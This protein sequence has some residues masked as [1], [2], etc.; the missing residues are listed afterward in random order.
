MINL[1]P[2]KT[3]QQLNAAHANTILLK[4]LVWL[5]TAVA[6]L[7][8]A[9]SVSYMFLA[10]AQTEKQDLANNSQSVSSLY[11]SAQTKLN[12]IN[13]NIATAKTLLL[14]QISYSEAITNLAS[15]MP[16]G[17]VLDKLVLG[18]NTGA[19]A[20][21]S[22]K[23]RAKSEEIAAKMKDNFQKSS[24]FANYSQTTS[25]NP[26][27]DAATFPILINISLTIKKGV[28]L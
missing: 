1:L 26:G 3:Q 25:T 4:S 18:G 14:Q 8:L 27:S 10:D 11:T 7:F 13:K 28:S 19:N 21:T 20:A 17:V 23:A 15:L 12:T 5:F 24:L 2:E 16:T 22:I 6:F 9:C